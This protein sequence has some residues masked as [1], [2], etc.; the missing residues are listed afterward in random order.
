MATKFNS[1][2]L[3]F[4]TTRSTNYK[5]KRKRKREKEKKKKREKK[6]KER[7]ERGKI[8]FLGKLFFSFF[9][10]KKKHTE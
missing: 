5:R 6:R 2:D 9:K 7:K 1:V 8:F 3:R 4:S 10:K